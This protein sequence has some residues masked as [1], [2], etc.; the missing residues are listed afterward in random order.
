MCIIYELFVII[1]VAHF[2]SFV[3]MYTCYNSLYGERNLML[4]G[5]IK[6]IV[7]GILLKLYNS[8]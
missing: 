6:Y 8:Y 7:E 2:Y 4:I 5:L 1:F 3:I